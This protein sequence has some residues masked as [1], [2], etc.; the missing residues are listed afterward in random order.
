MKKTPPLF[1]YLTLTSLIV[2]HY[3]DSVKILCKTMMPL[4]DLN[5]TTLQSTPK[6][7]LHPWFEFIYCLLV[8]ATID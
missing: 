7:F 2:L 1:S 3:L 8:S 5:L 4:V 6:N